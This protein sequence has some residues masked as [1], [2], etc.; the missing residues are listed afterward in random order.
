MWWVVVEWL[1]ALGSFTFCMAVYSGDM[2]WVVF[3]G[4]WLC[5]GCMLSVDFGNCYG[6]SSVVDYF[7][8]A[9]LGMVDVYG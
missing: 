3:L 8:V 7:L 5:D 2:W 9:C 4:G 6:V 1:R